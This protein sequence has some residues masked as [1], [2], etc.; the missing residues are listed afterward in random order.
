V[1]TAKTQAK[2]GRNSAI[3]GVIV[4]LMLVLGGAL[5]ISYRYGFAPAS[6]RPWYAAHSR[7]NLVFGM[8]EGA[9]IGSFVGVSIPIRKRPDGPSRRGTDR[10]VW[11]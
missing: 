2:N 5:Y 3:A 11:G 4:A 10:C 9:M 6:A 1:D 8:L 7:A